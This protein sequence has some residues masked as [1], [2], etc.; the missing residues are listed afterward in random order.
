MFKILQNIFDID[1]TLSK[2]GNKIRVIDF[3][4]LKGELIVS[5]KKMSYSI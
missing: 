4:I 1:V 3:I 5:S 2:D